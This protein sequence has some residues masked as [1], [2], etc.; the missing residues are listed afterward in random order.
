MKRKLSRVLCLLLMIITLTASI[1]TAAFAASSSPITVMLLDKNHNVIKTLTPGSSYKSKTYDF[2]SEKTQGKVS[3]KYTAGAP[4]GTYYLSFDDGNTKG[5]YGYAVF[6]NIASIV[7]NVSNPNISHNVVIETTTSLHL[8]SYGDDIYDG[9]AAIHAPDVNLTIRGLNTYDYRPSINIFQYTHRS[10]NYYSLPAAIYAET[11]NIDGINTHIQNLVNPAADTSG[12]ARLTAF[13]IRAHKGISINDSTVD[14][15]FDCGAS[16]SGSWKIVNSDGTPNYSPDS[17][18]YG[19]YTKAGKIEMKSS[20]LN[21]GSKVDLV[22]K[23][24]MYSEALKDEYVD[25]YK[26]S[27]FYYG[28]YNEADSETYEYSSTKSKYTNGQ[29]ILTDSGYN[30][31]I[32]PVR[33]G[34]KFAV[35]SV[36]EI[37]TGGTLASKD[38]NFSTE[39][40][41]ILDNVSYNDRGLNKTTTRGIE[42][43]SEPSD[44]PGVVI[45]NNSIVNL[46]S[47][48][49]GAAFRNDTVDRDFTKTFGI[50]SRHRGVLIQDSEVTIISGLP[51]GDAALAEESPEDAIYGLQ[52]R[53]SNVRLAA[54]GSSAFNFKYKSGNSKSDIYISKGEVILETTEDSATVSTTPFLISN[55]Y[56]TVTEGSYNSSTMLASGAENIH[57][58]FYRPTATTGVGSQFKTKK[59]FTVKAISNTKLTGSV[60]YS[61]DEARV[62]VSITA[63][64][65]TNASSSSML[66]YQW[67]IYNTRT[68]MFIDI[69]D[70]TDAT[71]TPTDNL[72]G[73]LIRVTVSSP[74]YSAGTVNGKSFIV[75]E[76]TKL[77]GEIDYKTIDTSE[78][79][80]SKYIIA[81]FLTSQSISGLSYQWQASIDN[82]RT[83]LD[84]PNMTDNYVKLTPSGSENK[85]LMLRVVVTAENHTGS[86]RGAAIT[87]KPPAEFKLPFTDVKAKNWFYNDVLYVYKYGLMNGVTKTLFEPNT[88]TTR[89]MFVTVLYRLE[90]SPEV[91]NDNAFKDVKTGFYYDNPIR[92]ATANGIVGGYGNGKFGPE[93]EITREQMATILYRYYAYKGEDVSE[94]ADISS[95]KDAN[96]IPSYAVTPFKWAVNR[97]IIKG[98]TDTTLE[99]LEK[100]TRA[101]IAAILNRISKVSVTTEKV[102][103]T[104]K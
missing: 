102:L 14:I 47:I 63:V 95:Y 44:N 3:L 13:G 38:S 30:M 8:N 50:L 20:Q 5:D 70:A 26:D 85:E 103:I 93:D 69:P 87:I 28:I 59:S 79:D 71:F 2:A 52:I 89:G 48:S 92:W 78:T 46:C 51:I 1:P 60:T 43:C 81:S 73:A 61:A 34:A 104:K 75:Q 31:Y 35:T 57:N 36:Q 64:A 19:L 82:G 101:Q 37:Y 45:K 76:A 58:I 96:K 94:L 29:V 72:E 97:G 7:I 84:A 10:T 66:S 32:S 65:D 41:V 40:A 98:M 91:T 12:Q 68:K 100:A 56:S 15:D 11:V 99:P 16:D 21:F 80:S 74:Y 23:S 27:I 42:D 18:F 90:G 83:W 6:S 88:T 77:Q 55:L 9:I 53:D 33:C 17:H 22:S 54:L 49:Y 62:G 25:A 4:N 39:P 86:V 24:C 67:Q